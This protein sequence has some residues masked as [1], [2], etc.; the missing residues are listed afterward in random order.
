MANWA[1]ISAL[2]ADLISVSSILS[3][4]SNPENSWSCSLQTMGLK[5]AAE[6]KQ[7]TGFLT[8]VNFDASSDLGADTKAHFVI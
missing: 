5:D 8:Q 4:N 3:F 7:V 1:R 6:L 2:L